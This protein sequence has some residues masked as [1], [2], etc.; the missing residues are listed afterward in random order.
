MEAIQI[1]DE[2][3]AHLRLAV[4]ERMSDNRYQH[5]LSV[6]GE[7]A[8]LASYYF[9]EK[10]NA[11]RAAALLHDVSK[12]L[13][14]EDHLLL[15][16][17]ARI[18]LPRGAERFPAVLHSYTAEAVIRLHFPEFASEEILSA[19]RRHTVGHPNMSTFDKLLFLADYIEPTRRHESCRALR[20]EF[21]AALNDAGSAPEAALALDRAIYRAV[22]QTVTHLE[23]E[24]LPIL[25]ETYEV[26]KAFSER[27]SG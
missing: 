6:E 25:P 18:P 7:C 17:H 8:R 23:A 14:T 24:Q 4:R 26:Y 21:Y 2:M 10:E 22:S 16:E 1:T 19:I 12:A 13:S 27:I 3:L 11:L 5:T 20:R 15:A 9:P